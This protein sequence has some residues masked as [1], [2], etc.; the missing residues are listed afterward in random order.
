MI[1]NR[2]GLAN[3]ALSSRNRCHSTSRLV[4]VT[5]SVLPSYLLYLRDQGHYNHH[6]QH[7]LDVQMA[8]SSYLELNGNV[9]PHAKDEVSSALPAP[10]VPFP[11]PFPWPLFCPLFQ[12]CLCLCPQISTKSARKTTQHGRNMRK[13]G[14]KT[15]QDKNH[16][17]TRQGKPHLGNLKKSRP[18]T[19]STSCPLHC[20]SLVFVFVCFSFVV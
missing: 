14:D 17:A 1:C 5:T 7:D 8:F 11:F 20:P 19:I 9:N 4:R 6:K 2:T 3:A 12:S 13:I 15:R 16:R 10:S 18:R